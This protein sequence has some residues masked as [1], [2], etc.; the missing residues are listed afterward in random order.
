MHLEFVEPTK[1]DA[2][3]IVPQGGAI[4]LLLSLIRPRGLRP[5]A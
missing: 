5:G 3:I 4:G 1:R 2:D